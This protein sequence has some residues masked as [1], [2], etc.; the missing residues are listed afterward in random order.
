MDEYIT[1]KGEGE[2]ILIEKKSRFLGHCSPVTSK[3]QAIEFINSIKSIYKDASHNVGAYNIRIGGLNHSSDDGEPSGTAGVPVL[4]TLLKAKIVDAAVV[5]TRY[6]GGILLGAGGLIRAYSSTASAALR[7]AKIV[8]MTECV[9][10]DISVTY[11]LYE[12][13]T[14]LLDDMNI[15]INSRNFLDKVTIQ[16]V[17]KKDNEHNLV[18]QLTEFFRGRDQ[19]V[20][21]REE[22]LP[23]EIFE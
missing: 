13:L 8:V 21:V 18:N 2:S 11:P 6:F 3:E 5:V 14:K 10:Y 1:L 12:R 7:D 15:T 19:F 22:Y 17:T 4:E 9:V 20:L 23:L 16:C